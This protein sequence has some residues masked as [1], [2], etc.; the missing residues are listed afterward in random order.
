MKLSYFLEIFLQQSYL[1]VSSLQWQTMPKLPK[2]ENT[3]KS[4]TN[5]WGNFDQ[6]C[7]IRYKQGNENLFSRNFP[8]TIVCTFL[9][10]NGPK[11]P[12]Y[13]NTEKSRLDG[14]FI[15]KQCL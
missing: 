8:P 10:C 14:D 6:M 1:H 2:Y 11:L 3:E 9:H 13:E 12:K 4:R 15:G 7:K 5:G